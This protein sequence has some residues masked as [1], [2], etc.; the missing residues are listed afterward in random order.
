MEIGNSPLVS[1]IVPCYNHERY[2]E[3]CIESI[4]NQSFKEFE[5]IVIDDGSNDDSFGIIKR[6]DSKY[7]FLAKKQQNIGL[8]ATLN[9]AIS[10]YAKGKYISICASDDYWEPDKLEKQV[11][12]LEQ[13][14]EYPMVYGKSHFVDENS[15]RIEKL[16]YLND[17]LKGG[18]IFEDIILFK[19][20]P[21][22]TYMY[23]AS[24]FDEVGLFPVD[25]ST[26]DFYMNLKISSRYKIGFIND[27]LGSY[28]Y[29]D[30]HKKM[31]TRHNTLD[32]HERCI[33]DY[34]NTR[35][36]SKSLEI[37]RLSKINIAAPFIKY[38]RL[39]IK[40]I[41]T[42]YKYMFT[43]GYLKGIIKVLFV[44]KPL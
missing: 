39:A 8:C 6:L 31:L 9:L 20:H 42:N 17:G 32:A 26:D 38:K 33:E 22:V 41:L 25:I 13:N 40:E 29:F 11:N 21:P 12:F 4:Y 27:Y 35:F 36:Y 1:V 28:R 37:I 15:N 23:R 7:N 16:D 10:K 19:F 30:V 18:D 44:W 34:K 2:V 3:Q 14:P 24:I 5:L 43:L